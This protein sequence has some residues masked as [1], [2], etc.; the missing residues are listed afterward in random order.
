MNAAL[1]S[2]LESSRGAQLV[3]LLRDMPNGWEPHTVL[4]ILRAKGYCE[5]CGADVLSSLEAFWAGKWDHIIPKNRG[6]E[7]EKNGTP[8]D[9]VFE[10]N[11]ALACYKCNE[12]KGED[13]P[14]GAAVEDLKE[15]PREE[16]IVA[17]RPVVL[18]RRREYRVVEVFAAFRELVEMVRGGLT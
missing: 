8:I 9:V 3:K 11:I 17:F 1:D 7:H 6:G 16:R 14:H 4:A 12:L 5:Y 2:I 15:L 10:K 13:V 18:E